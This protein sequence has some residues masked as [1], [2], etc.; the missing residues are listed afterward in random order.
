MED[1]WPPVSVVI[2]VRN[3]AAFIGRAMR[4]ALDQEY[5]GRLE[6]VVAVATSTD[7]TRAEALRIADGDRR[8]RVVDNLRD[9]TPAGLNAAITASAGEVIVRCD[10]QAVLPPGYVRRAVELIRETGADVVGGTQAATGESLLQRAVAIAM[11]SPLGT[12]GARF[13]V[14]GPPGPT[15]TVYLGVFRRA[16]L[17]RVG[18]FDEAMVRNQD[19]EL[20]H[21]IRASGG[22]VYYSPDLVVP[23]TPRPTLRALADQYRQYGDWKRK[24]LRRH[25]ES[26]RGRQLAAPLL[27]LALAASIVLGFTPWRPWGLVVP[28]LYAGALTVTA[29]GELVRRRDVAALVTPPAIVTMHLAWGSGFL[30]SDGIAPEPEIPRLEDV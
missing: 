29:V 8:V 11:T 10:A 25:P 13:R 14:G 7:G 2:P 12:G 17:A 19:Y 3:A 9:L 4:A 1:P 28:S 16:A 18:L 21:R 5:P 30:L 23:Y 27:V 26:V 22:V 24:M 20:N 6:L 15:D